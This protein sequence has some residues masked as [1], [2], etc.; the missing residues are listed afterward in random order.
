MVPPNYLIATFISFGR[1][2]SARLLFKHE[3]FPRIP[4]SLLRHRCFWSA[5]PISG[6]FNLSISHAFN[7]PSPIQSSRRGPSRKARSHPSGLLFLSVHSL[8]CMLFLEILALATHGRIQEV[9]QSQKWYSKDYGEFSNRSEELQGTPL[10]FCVDLLFQVIYALQV[11]IT[12]LVLVIQLTASPVLKLNFTLWRVELVRVSANLI[13][14]LYLVELLYRKCWCSLWGLFAADWIFPLVMFSGE[15]MRLP[16]VAHH[17]LTIFVMS[18][19][20]V[21]LDRTH[22]PSFLLSG[23]IWIFQATTEQCKFTSSPSE[24]LEVQNLTQTSF[25]LLS[26]TF[27]AL[28]GYRLKWPAHRVCLLLRFSAIQSLICKVAAITGSIYIWAQW[29]SSNTSSYGI[30]NSIVVWIVTVGLAI[31]QVWGSWV[32]WKI[33]DSLEERYRDQEKTEEACGANLPRA[34]SIIEVLQEKNKGSSLT[35][36]D[37]I[38]TGPNSSSSTSVG[39]ASWDLPDS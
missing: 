16:M 10:M 19:I 13:A 25:L 9:E 23:L 26:V 35:P 17:F 21:M 14:G 3:A 5:N 34:T 18:F 8:L 1:T 31:T 32:V 28:A 12:S 20:V 37:S 30:A 7:T 27:I 29:Q 2:S 38:F 33:G 4:C 36:A 24:A 11:F 22:D 15:R 6:S 39:V